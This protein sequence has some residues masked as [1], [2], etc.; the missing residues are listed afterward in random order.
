MLYGSYSFLG[1]LSFPVLSNLRSTYTFLDNI[2]YRD[3]CYAFFWSAMAK[4]KAK[5][6]FEL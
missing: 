3:L 6:G 4:E 2:I 5:L 1:Q